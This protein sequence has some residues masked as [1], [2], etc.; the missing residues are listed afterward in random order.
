MGRGGYYRDFTL[1]VLD[2]MNPLHFLFSSKNKKRN[3]SKSK[4]FS[5]PPLSIAYNITIPIACDDDDR[6][7]HH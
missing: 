1:R 3:I 4:Q 7:S 5:F 6:E 2:V